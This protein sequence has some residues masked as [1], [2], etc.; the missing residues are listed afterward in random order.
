MHDLLFYNNRDTTVYCF[1]TTEISQSIVLQQKRYH[2]LLFYNNRDNTVYCFTTK[3]ISRSIVFISQSHCSYGY[4]FQPDEKKTLHSIHLNKIE[5]ESVEH[6]IAPITLLL[7][8]YSLK[9]Y[10]SVE[11]YLLH[12][13][14][15]SS[16]RQV[17]IE[18]LLIC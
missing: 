16:T 8:R 10:E 2:G 9:H 5:I 6:Y 7:D 12:C 11:H 17:L 15:H 13:P 4:S 1:T 18:T 14:N 3:E